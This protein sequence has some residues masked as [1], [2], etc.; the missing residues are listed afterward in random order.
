MSNKDNLFDVSLDDDANTNNYSRLN[1]NNNNNTRSSPTN[2]FSNDNSIDNSESSSDHAKKTNQHITISSTVKAE[3]GLHVIENDENEDEDH[4]DDDDSIFG[5]H[6]KTPTTHQHARFADDFDDFS[7]NGD[8][9]SDS[10]TAKKTLKAQNHHQHTGMKRLRWAT[11]RHKDGKPKVGRAKTLKWAKNKFPIHSMNQLY[12][13]DDVDVNDLAGESKNRSAEKRT[14]FFNLDLPPNMVDEEGKPLVIYPRNK[15]RTT[16]YT[17]L[18]FVPKNLLLQFNNIANGYFLFMVILGAFSIFGVTN[19]GFSAV[20]L[21]VIVCIT[22]IKD[23]I[24]DSRR[25]ILDL[26]VNNTTTHLLTGVEN[27][28]CSDDNISAWRKFKKSCTKVT[29]ASLK[30]ISA[31]MTKKGRAELLREKHKREL[32]Q[33]ND[34]FQMP[35]I[36]G[37]GRGSFDSVQDYRPSLDDPRTSMHYT[38]NEMKKFGNLI[39]Y[40]MPYDE[41]S[42]FKKSFWKDVKVGD[43]VRIHMNDEIPADVILLSTSDP[44]GACYVETKNLDGETNLKVKQSLKCSNLIRTSRDI[45][46][47]K[48][49]LESEGPH[50]NLYSYQGNL[51]WNE[52]QQNEDSHSGSAPV[53]R[54][55]PVTINN[56]LLRGC[57]LRNTKW[58]MG[59]VVFT[60]DE[61]KI[62]LNAGVTPTK[63][64]RISRELNWSV[65][66]NFFLLFCLCLIAGVVNGVFYDENGTSRKYFEFGTVAKTP[67]AN[68]V[69]SF[70]VAL[71]LYQSLIPIS[72]YISVEIIKTAQALFIYGDL[73]MYNEKLDYPCTPKS[74]NISDDLG[75]IEY[76]FSDKTGTLTQNVMEFKK[77]SINGVSYGRAYTEA[78]QGLRKRQGIDVEEE[79][80]REREG[81]KQDKEFVIEK[82]PKIGSGNSQFFPDEITFI[83]KDFVQDLEGSKG[84][85]QKNCNE[86]FMLALALCHTVLTEPSKTVEGKLDYKAQSPD[87][88]ALVC[89]ARDMGYSFITRT[90]TGVVVEVQG[91]EKEFEVLNILE[92]NS[93]RKRMS[94]IIKLPG[95]KPK[96]LLLSKGA[97]SI[98]YS[99]LSKTG[100]DEALLD[101]TAKHLEEFATEGLRTLC[102]AQREIEWEQYLEWNARHDAASSSLNDREGAM[103]RVADEIEQELILLGGTAIEDRLQDGVPDSIALL[104]EA[105]IKLWVLTGDKVETAINIGFSCNLLGNDMELLI[106]N[107]EV[108]EEDRENN[109]HRVMEDDPVT[110]VERNITRY[111][112]DKFG[113]SGSEE[114]LEEAKKEHEVPKGEFGVVVDGNALKLALMN[115]EVSRKFL[116]L[117]KNCKAVLCCRVSPAQKAAV[118]KLVKDTLDVMTLAIGD[119]S[120]DV[121]MIQSADV[122]VGIA[123]EEG[124]QAV[125]SSDYAIGQFRY[126]TRLI[127]V[128]GRWSYKRLS[129]M[130]PCFFYKNV[131]FTL[132]L[133]WYGIYNDFDGSYLFE[134]TYLS[135]YNLAF[136]SLPVIFLGILDQDVSDVVSVLVPQLYRS[137]ILRTEWTM[138]KFWGYMIDGLY[139]SVIAFYF[140]YVLYSK[141]GLVSSNGLGLTARYFLG[142][143]VTAISACACD[144]FVLMKQYR[145]DWF[146][147]FWVAI[148]I[149]VF[150]GWTGIWTSALRSGEFY[151]A[152]ARVFGAPSFWAVLFVG[153][154]FCLLPRFTFDV[155]QK[156]FFPRDIDIIRE[157]WKRGDFDQYPPDYDPTDP[158]RRKI[159]KYSLDALSQ[160]EDSYLVEDQEKSSSGILDE[161]V[162]PMVKNNKNSHQRVKSVL[163]MIDESVPILSG[164]HIS[165]A[166]TSSPFEN[167]LDNDI[168]LSN[169]N[170]INSGNNKYHQSM[171]T[172][173]TEEIP[174]DIMENHIRGASTNDR[175][176]STDQYTRYSQ[177]YHRRTSPF[178]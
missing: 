73:L 154:L 158:N 120:N 173:Q 85:Y 29:W 160:I 155:L 82:L 20:P 14:I 98:I 161:D 47:T 27:F 166:T 74:W 80:T 99:R 177:D 174:L 58:A 89:T 39:D 128:H 159:S 70:F 45:V 11:R 93:T 84:D 75:Q 19:P 54:Q 65:I 23:A 78:L 165:S 6:V 150:F 95:D 152:A 91:V 36:S 81:I 53:L 17:P 67:A 71:I 59:L 156:M 31:R 21:I 40:N 126:L 9:D 1:G 141:T 157:C 24:E 35:R 117:C 153:I 79:G 123:G 151:K 34:N 48:F 162:N 140:P 57:T 49:W 25:T 26:Q 38:A 122:G 41:E 68:G 171:D 136:T 88:A 61:T 139:Q 106:I 69:V 110:I 132:A 131:V 22:A 76:I 4:D 178:N 18:N 77:C 134:Y 42:K 167:E 63:K 146:T 112:H 32:R 50:P 148:S 30:Y 113:M 72:L 8:N 46:R 16:K 149:L 3:D 109:A 66:L 44:D 114:E 144:L 164:R 118:V 108:S 56:M 103:E 90:K 115:K 52:R 51:Q 5:D 55:E 119:G 94:C 43:V 135:F 169:G 97:D 87:E 147:S 121:A 125:M 83:S 101:A 124:R 100:N 86:H 170:R 145:W 10:D 142:V 7:D 33:M 37:N 172:I 168:G 15:I 28:N 96:A 13:S 127:L 64:S 163:S 129:E 176:T 92:F 102:V 12:T 105:G 137:G 111:L 107:D 116:L 62:I 104:G 130:I 138:K 60:G 2:P 175:R 133:F 143:P